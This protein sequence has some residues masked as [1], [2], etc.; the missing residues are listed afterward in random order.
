MARPAPSRP[1]RRP[2]PPS[3]R[4]GRPAKSP[5]TNGRLNL[6]SLIRHVP[7]FPKPGIVFRDITPLLSHPAGFRQAIRAL[8]RTV[9]PWK[10]D[11]IVGIESRGFIFGA[12]VALALGV[13]FA[14]VRKKGKLPFRT[15][16]HSYS[17]EY[18]T[19][20][21]E[22][23][24]DAVRPGQRVV[25]IDDLLATGGTLAAACALVESTG[26][27]VAGCACLIELAFLPGRRKLGARP[28]AAILRYEAE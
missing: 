10:P 2:R 24:E 19:D 25:V 27:R 11:A 23:H 4:P 17:L 5:S 21:I 9:R 13:P 15:R 20:T 14:P 16:S 6:A 18:G 8:T 7:D 28:F 26:A 12:P 3:R 22:I 1:P